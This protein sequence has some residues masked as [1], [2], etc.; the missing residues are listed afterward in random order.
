M[1]IYGLAKPVNDVRFTLGDNV[2]GLQRDT[3][4]DRHPEFV[5]SSAVHN[6][7]VGSICPKQNLGSVEKDIEVEL[8]MHKQSFLI[9]K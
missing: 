6:D 9:L 5:S 4:I 2:V 8:L 1:F 3:R 7:P